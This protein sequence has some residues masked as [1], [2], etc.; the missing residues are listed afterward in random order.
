MAASTWPD[1]LTR[2]PV[3]VR[4]VGRKPGAGY[5][6]NL[7]PRARHPPSRVS[8]RTVANLAAECAL[9]SSGS[10]EGASVSPLAAR[11]ASLSPRH[12][13]LHHLTLATA[14]PGHRTSMSSVSSLT[15][16]PYSADPG[17]LFDQAPPRDI[18]SSRSTSG[19]S[20]FESMVACKS[21]S[22]PPLT[23]SQ[24]KRR[25]SS[26]KFRPLAGSAQCGGGEEDAKKA[27]MAQLP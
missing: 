22:M 21:S 5:R 26:E 14:R 16:A 18:G 7:G 24:G 23:R 19:G 2:P 10:E 12:L 9:W 27:R 3:T 4:S 25:H 11:P 17:L 15:A 20:G 1:S 13:P 6:R 8:T